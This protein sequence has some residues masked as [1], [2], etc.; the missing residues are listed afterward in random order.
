[1]RIRL[2]S[3]NLPGQGN[4]AVLLDLDYFLAEEKS[5]EF[6][7]VL[8]WVEEAHG[9]IVLMFEGTITDELRKRFG[10]ER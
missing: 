8:N 2:T 6:K 7:N 9:Q 1:M 4:P 3:E 10:E 5:V